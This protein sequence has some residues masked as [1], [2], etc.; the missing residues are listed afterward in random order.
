MAVLP[1]FTIYFVN[2]Y[3]IYLTDSYVNNL[4]IFKMKYNS[5]SSVFWFQLFH[6]GVLYCFT[7][8]NMHRYSPKNS[9]NYYEF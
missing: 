1:L 7:Y 8:L 3:E 2:K 4:V 6:E 5:V 9:D